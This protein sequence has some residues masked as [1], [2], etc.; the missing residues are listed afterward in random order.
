MILF[1]I[2]DQNEAFAAIDLNVILLL[3]GMMIIA[4]ITAK[5]GVFQWIAV[6]AVRR[7]QGR[8]Y[9]LLVLTS[10]VTAVV[11]AFLDNVTTVVLLAPVTFFIAQRLGTS[12][13][14]FLIS[15]VIASNIG[16]TA[17]LIGDRSEE[18]RVGKECRSRW[19]RWQ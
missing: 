11:S 10:V 4:N 9:A 1:R 15:Q 6:E 2:V 12:P 14:A 7:A 18:R 13:V 16:G 8:P 5:T 17:T 19:A 3:A